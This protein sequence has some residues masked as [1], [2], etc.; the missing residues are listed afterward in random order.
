MKRHMRVRTIAV[1]LPIFLMFIGC[2]GTDNYIVETTQDY[3]NQEIRKD[4]WPRG[5]LPPPLP[6][7]RSVKVGKIPALFQVGQNGSAN[8]N[9]PIEVLPG[10]GGIQPH[11]SLSYNS[12]GGTSFTGIRFTLN[13]LSVI[14]RQG[15]SCTQDGWIESV[16]FNEDDHFA[17]DGNR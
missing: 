10:R 14:S 13:G 15:S 6:R 1:I 2:A 11:L 4:S 16:N 8:Y 7:E 12:L 5:E 3:P 9:I 17:L